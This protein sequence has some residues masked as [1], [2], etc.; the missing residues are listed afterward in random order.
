[1]SHASSKELFRVF[2]DINNS[3]HLNDGDSMPLSLSNE[4]TESK[5][6]SI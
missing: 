4:M 2:R 3:I 5:C 6:T 1:M